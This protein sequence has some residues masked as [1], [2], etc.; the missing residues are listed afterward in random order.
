MGAKR[1][2]RAIHYDFCVFQA[3]V[4]CKPGNHHRG[5]KQ[6]QGIEG[7]LGRSWHEQDAIQPASGK[8]NVKV[9]SK[10]KGPRQMFVLDKTTHPHHVKGFDLALH[11]DETQPPL[12][13]SFGNRRSS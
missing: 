10:E 3:P 9:A 7:A 8:G 4:E 13:A 1:G 2:A 11:V 6:R 5:I 12:G